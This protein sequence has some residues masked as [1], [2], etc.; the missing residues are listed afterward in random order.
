MTILCQVCWLLFLW[1]IS[2]TY[3]HSILGLGQYHC[4]PEEEITSVTS[5][6]IKVQDEDKPF[7]CLGTMIYKADEQEPVSGRLLIFSAFTSKTPSK[8]SSL[9]LSLITS[10]K[11][12]GCVYALKIVKDR[13]VAAVNSSVRLF[14]PSRR[15]LSEICT[16]SFFIDLRPRLKMSLCHSSR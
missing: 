4:E 12:E 9:E 11:V 15:P 5:F 8:K 1:E 6:S 10:V 2:N 13:I 7:F 14:T 3:L 16:R